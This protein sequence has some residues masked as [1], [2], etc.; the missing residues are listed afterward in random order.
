MK[1]YRIHGREKSRRV[2]ATL[3]DLR[4][5]DPIGAWLKGEVPLA[6]AALAMKR[7]NVAMEA[8]A[9]KEA[10]SAAPSKGAPSMVGKAASATASLGAVAVSSDTVTTSSPLAFLALSA[11]TT[12]SSAFLFREGSSSAMTGGTLAT[13]GWPIFFAPVLQ[14]YR[15]SKSDPN[16]MKDK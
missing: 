11:G 14:L 8:P 7:G 6:V 5:G 2:P 1:L 4:I 15:V 13:D 9:P 12:T 3:L 10:G 16:T